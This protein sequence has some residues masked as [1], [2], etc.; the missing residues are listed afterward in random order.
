MIYRWWADQEFGTIF[1]H[2]HLFANYRQK[3]GLFGALLIEPIGARF[4]DI[5][6]NKRI[7]SGL[8]ARIRMPRLDGGLITYTWFR[9]FCLAIADFIP[10]WDRNG[11]ALN[12]PHPPGGHGDQG[13][14][15]LNYRMSQ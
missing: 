1:F 14:M 15:A 5:F 11:D 6:S 2:D 13:V 7:V 8:Q 3:H 4:Y 12:P 10:M 9:E